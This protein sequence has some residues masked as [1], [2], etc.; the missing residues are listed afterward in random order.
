ME[1][2]RAYDDEKARN[3]G[4]SLRFDSYFKALPELK[5]EVLLEIGFARTAPNEPRDFTSWALERALQ[6]N[7][8]VIDNRASPMYQKKIDKVGPGVIC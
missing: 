6:A 3:G 2:N 5:P 1:R 4:V 8:D 7:V